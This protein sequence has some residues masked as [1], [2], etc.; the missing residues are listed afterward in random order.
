MRDN[1][2]LFVQKRFASRFRV[3]SCRHR[4]PRDLRVG[5]DICAIG[6]QRNF[7]QCW[8]GEDAYVKMSIGRVCGFRLWGWSKDGSHA[9]FV[10]ELSGAENLELRIDQSIDIAK[11]SGGSRPNAMYAVSILTGC[12]CCKL[13]PNERF[14]CPAGL[15]R[16]GE[17]YST[18]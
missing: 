3:G 10:G 7:I 6:S 17:K 5:H 8:C 2:Y 18:R 4:R 9:T 14:Q 11:Q 13:G 12:V 16:L 1:A 15:A